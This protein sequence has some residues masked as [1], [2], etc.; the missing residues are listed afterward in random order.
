MPAAFAHLIRTHSETETTAL[1]G[2]I[3]PRLRPGDTLLLTG[4]I[5]AGKTHFARALIQ[6]R[7]AAG[8]AR[9]GCAF[10]HIHAGAN[11][12]RRHLPRSGMPTSIG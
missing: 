12:R 8:G 1:A 3:A 4:P 5:G 2:R 6:A 9:R 10:A 7:L 11:L